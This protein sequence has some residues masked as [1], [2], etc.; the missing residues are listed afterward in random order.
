[1]LVRPLSPHGQQA[2]QYAF[3]TTSGALQPVIPAAL[4]SSSTTSAGV[5]GAP[6]PLLPESGDSPPPLPPKPPTHIA[7]LSDTNTQTP[8]GDNTLPTVVTPVSPKPSSL[9]T[10]QTTR[11]QEPR[12][13][14]SWD[15]STFNSPSAARAR[16]QPVA[17]PSSMGAG[18]NFEGPPL[19]GIEASSYPPFTPT[20]DDRSRRNGEGSGN[21]RGGY[22]P[23]Y[24]TSHASGSGSGSGRP[25][26]QRSNSQL[27]QGYPSGRTASTSDGNR[28][29]DT[30]G[31]DPNFDVER[32]EQPMYPPSRRN[33]RRSSF[34]DARLRGQAHQEGTTIGGDDG[35]GGGL[36][37]LL[38]WFGRNR[39]Q[40]RKEA[41]E[42][43]EELSALSRDKTVAERLAPTLVHAREALRKARLEGM[44]ISMLLHVVRRNHT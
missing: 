14:L 43:A 39:R 40:R 34:Y 2:L 5:S 33:T 19:T 23:A 36:W 26:F 30:R 16:G 12:R 41:S 7:S 4:P 13:G 3:P 8:G 29:S 28:Q 20:R 21:G 15:E 18:I 9:P 22:S 11:F 10:P 37:R 31:E 25:R 42:V 24:P 38:S 35:G 27:R 32:G 44:Y 1:M 17:G 6:P